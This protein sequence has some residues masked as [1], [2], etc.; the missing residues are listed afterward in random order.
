MLLLIGE[1]MLSLKIKIGALS[2]L[3]LGKKDNGNNSAINGKN[4]L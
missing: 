2:E 1:E 4:I 3:S